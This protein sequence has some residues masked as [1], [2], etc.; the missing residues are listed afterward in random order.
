MLNIL[1]YCS[2]LVKM[3]VSSPDEYIV[4]LIEFYYAYCNVLT[5]LLTD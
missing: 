5:T 4:K 2:T 3:L 1:T